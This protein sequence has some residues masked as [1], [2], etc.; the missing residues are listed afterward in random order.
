MSF[1]NWNTDNK[2]IDRIQKAIV[3]GHVSH[4]YIIEGDNSVDKRQFAL[5]FVKAILC[6]D[7]PGIG[8]DNC[9]NCQKINH[10]NYE[11]LYYVEAEYNTTKTSK[12]IRD[13]DIEEL[14]TK[15][16]MKP[17]GE[18]NVALISDSDTMTLRAQN[19]L[20]KTLEEPY[21]GTVIVLLSENSENL[22]DTIKSRA[23]L[24]HIYGDMGIK[25]NFAPGAKEL[26]NSVIAHEKFFDLK[27]IIAKNVKS[28]E[29]AMNL[30]DSMEKIYRNMLL[31][32]DSRSSLVKKEKIFEDVRLIE[33]A[34]RDLLTKV[35]YNYALKDLVLKL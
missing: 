31:G 12:A 20:L 2:L 18:R 29:D 34:R 21:P 22:I 35:N 8:C 9:I 3:N 15:L 11:D 25:G 32:E 5:D 28:R 30:L 14:Q 17:Y 26:V 4:A 16:K 27:E 24:Y 10:G 7:E 13:E 19:R 23:I 1:R 6:K 33:E